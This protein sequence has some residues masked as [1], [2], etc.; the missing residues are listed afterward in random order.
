[1]R[2]AV[3]PGQMAINERIKIFD[4]E[5]NEWVKFFEMK[6]GDTEYK[7]LSPGRFICRR[8][9]TC[10][11]NNFK[12]CKKDKSWGFESSSAQWYWKKVDKF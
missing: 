3:G 6:Y 1:M 10:T 8:V 12:D 4:P 9:A 11:V 5:T 7:E 2:R